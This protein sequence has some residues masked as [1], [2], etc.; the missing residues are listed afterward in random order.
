MGAQDI[1]GDTL[2]KNRKALRDLCRDIHD[3]PELGLRERRAVKWQ[4]E[5]LRGW[6]FSVESPVAGLETAYRAE[7][8]GA[9]PAF[10]VLAE[11]DALAG[12]GARLRTQP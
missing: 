2:L 1:I 12:G 6:G 3:N 11:Y 5:L 4:V 9:G 8:G 10:C 7:W